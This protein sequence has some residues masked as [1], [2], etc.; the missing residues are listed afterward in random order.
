MSE[1]DCARFL[2]QLDHGGEDAFRDPHAPTCRTCGAALRAAAT[3]RSAMSDRGQA[4]PGFAA[5]VAY[6]AWTDAR[7][8]RRASDGWGIRGTAIAGPVVASA[9]GIGMTF[10]LPHILDAVGELPQALGSFGGFPVP[11]LQLAAMG[12][13][14]TAFLALA[15]VRLSRR[16]I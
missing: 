16:R 3:M 10:A 13:L 1:A 15:S 5:R 6:L 7:E 11:V 9:L 8:R 14:G 4:S 12:L 2:A